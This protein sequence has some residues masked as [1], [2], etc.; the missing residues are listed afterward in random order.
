MSASCN[1]L[2]ESLGLEGSDISNPAHFIR[3]VRKGVSGEVVRHAIQVFGNRSL[4]V[5]ILNTTS[6]NVS[7]YYSRKRL[8]HV[9][10]EELLDTIRLYINVVKIFGDIDSAKDWLQMPSP[11]LSGEKPEDLFDTFEGREW[12]TQVLRKIEYGEFV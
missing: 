11:A 7:R 12:V 8:S 4:F 10:S 2:L 6:S 3:S 1:A 9:D 5:K